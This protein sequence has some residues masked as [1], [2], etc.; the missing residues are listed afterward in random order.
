MFSIRFPRCCS[1]ESLI[2]L[3]SAYCLGQLR[4]LKNVFLSILDR[5]RD[6]DSRLLPIQMEEK[7]SSPI[8][9]IIGCKK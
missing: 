3:P 2:A 5:M 6:P 4:W 7:D 1:I 8:L 9:S